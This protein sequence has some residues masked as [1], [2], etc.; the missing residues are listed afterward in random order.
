MSASGNKM[1]RS[2]G[3]EQG[4]EEDMYCEGV[5]LYSFEDWKFLCWMNERYAY[6]RVDSSHHIRTRVSVRRGIIGG[7]SV[8][9]ILKEGVRM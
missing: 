3:W 4:V 7:I 2:K 1:D 6:P 5:R 9:S 8:H